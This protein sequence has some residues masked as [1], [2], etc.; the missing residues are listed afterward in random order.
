M[1]KRD[2]YDVLGVSRKA[3]ND[4]L[5]KAY[6]KLAK[7]LH[8]DV[9]KER[10]AEQKFKEINEA[11]DVLKDSQKRKA[12]NAFG[13]NAG[14]NRS[15]FNG[16]QNFG[17]GFGS[18]GFGNFNFEDLFSGFGGTGGSNPFSQNAAGTDISYNRNISFMDSVNGKSIYIDTKTDVACK[19]CKGQ[20]TLNPNDSTKCV[21]CNGKGQIN[22]SL[23]GLFV[24][25]M[26]C[27]TCQGQG[28]IIKNPCT[29]CSGKG[30]NLENTRILIKIPPGINT[31]QSIKMP[32]KGQINRQSGHKGDLYIKIFVDKDPIFKREENDIV[33]N[34]PIY[35]TSVITGVEIVVPTLTD[36]ENVTLPP[37]CVD[38]KRY[39]IKGV[40]GMPILKSQN[41]RF[42]L[43]HYG[44]F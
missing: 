8:P 6:R 34:V 33:V 28:K 29:N 40:K 15:N 16:Q 41:S 36:Y 44:D 32:G 38:K 5:K 43:K 25:T 9:N 35:F 24:T 13:H 7:K 10:G 12:Y 30:I 37:G 2:Y 26:P 27:R 1:A 42:S 31:G 39:R 11:Y 23:A 4:E 18:Q 3:T 14:A 21:T 22:Q 19:V 17:G 20:K